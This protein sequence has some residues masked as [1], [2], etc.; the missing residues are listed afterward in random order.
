MKIQEYFPRI[1]CINPTGNETSWTEAASRFKACGLSVERVDET[2]AEALQIPYGVAYSKADLALLLTFY[3]EVVRAYKDRVERFLVL[4][5]RAKFPKNFPSLSERIL[6]EMPFVW[7]LF[8]F[9]YQDA[10]FKDRP[11][12]G[13]LVYDIH[14]A[15]GLS[16]LAVNH[17]FY[18]LFLEDARVPRAP[19]DE[20]IKSV[21]L[22]A[23]IFCV[24]PPLVTISN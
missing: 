6:D 14:Y 13:Q 3:R 1:I 11:K 18:H 8:Y 5:S 24:N 12:K 7:D 16:G 22:A 19:L 23:N 20:H 10:S 9:G 2:P 4:T 15:N 21:S 17:R